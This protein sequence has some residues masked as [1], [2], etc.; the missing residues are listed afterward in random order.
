M[1]R[2]HCA[3]LRMR[4]AMR[5][6]CSRLRA[7]ARAA[8]TSSASVNA[9]AESVRAEFPALQDHGHAVF[10]DGAGG[11]Q[12]H[13]SV[14]EAVCTQ[15]RR[16]SANIGGEYPTSELCL[17]ATRDAR[18][19]AADLLHCRVS[20]V[21]FGANMTTLTFHLAHA[22]FHPGSI[23]PGDNIVL[24]KCVHIPAARPPRL[25]AL[26]CRRSFAPCATRLQDGP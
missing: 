19:A 3:Y 14:I 20:E 24:S 23:G 21:T 8:S 12:V 26:P 7:C 6:V 9:L 25:P 4:F 5:S 17:T 15:M 18:G 2:D 10:A 1:P 11:S 13:E 22:L 16:G